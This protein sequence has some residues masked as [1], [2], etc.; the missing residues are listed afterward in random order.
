MPKIR[1]HGGLAGLLL[2]IAVPC[3]VARVDS[4]ASRHPLP[5]PDHPRYAI[6]HLGEGIGLATATVTSLVQDQKGF[7]WMGTQNGL[8]RFD[9]IK[10]VR[11]GPKSG[12]LN[13]RV[14][15]LA[16]SPEGKLW[17]VVGTSVYQFDGVGFSEVALPKGVEIRGYPQSVALPAG[18][19]AYLATESGLLLLH[20]AEHAGG[21]PSY[22]LWST[23]S[24]LPLVHVTA[25]SA[26]QDGTVWL[27]GDGKLGIIRP[28]SHQPEM[29]TVRG[30]PNERVF[31]ILTDGA[32][33]VWVRTHDHIGYLDPSLSSYV[34]ADAGIPGANDFGAPTL[35]RSGNLML[36]TVM[37]LFRRIDGEWIN[38]GEKQGL[39]TNAV[40]AALEDRE[41]AIW[42]GLGGAGVD[43]WAGSENWSGWGEAEGLPD[44]VVWQVVRDHEQRLWAG[45]NNGL[46]MWDAAAHRWRVWRRNDGIAGITVRSLTVAG[47]GTIWALS[48]P[49]GLTRIDPRTLAPA[50]VP[51]PGRND[52]APVTLTTS[53]DG[54]VWMGAR[55]A[56]YVVPAETGTAEPHAVPIPPEVRGKTQVVSFAPDGTMWTDG[57]AGLARFDGHQWAAFTRADGLVEDSL[58]L[59][60]AVDATT[61]WVCYSESKGISR[62]H[63]E[64]GKLTVATFT[65]DQGLT[66]D[67]VYMLGRDFQGRIW[68]GGDRG[69]SLLNE[70]GVM[71]HFD[72]ATGLLWDDVDEGYIWN[73][74]DGSVLIATSRGI[75]RYTP[76]GSLSSRTPPA[77][78]LTSAEIGGKQYLNQS[79]V[80][81]PHDT[82]TFVVS[83]AAMTFQNPESLRC[84]YRLRGL[85]TELQETSQR[86]VRY[87]ALPPGRYEFTVRCGSVITGW[88]AAP[89]A[90]AFTIQPPWWAS[91]WARIGAL[92]LLALAVRAVVIYR[93][94][95]LEGDRLMLE[96]AVAERS[97][98]LAR[99][100]AELQAMSLTDPLTKVRNRRFFRETI[101]ADA[102]QVVRAYRRAGPNA[103]PIEHGDLIYYFVD[104]DHF[105]R[106][107]DEY[108]HYAGDRVLMECS[109]RLTHIVRQSDLLIR[110]G[111]EEFLVVLRSGTR[112]DGDILA[113]RLLRLMGEE[114][115]DIGDGKMIPMTC[116]IGWAA[117]PWIPSQPDALS[118]DD[119]LVL[120]DRAMYAAKEAGRNYAVGIAPGAELLRETSVGAPPRVDL[121]VPESPLVRLTRSLG[122]WIQA[123]TA[124]SQDQ[125]GDRHT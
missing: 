9:G 57:Y 51:P 123:P 98:E 55:S 25:V 1:R 120:A 73:D 119:V 86:E 90:F 95:S 82:S 94:R 24:G 48:V 22:Q 34:P 105:K 19:D 85:E 47:N 32:G 56:L 65:T 109:R 104:L 21:P 41:R 35:D 43:R 74:P 69:I 125:E 49:G 37:G 89:A 121:L 118:V 67:S 122:S 36:P 53:P 13:D 84:Q 81:V 114:P 78:V 80:Q 92:L 63:L 59:V 3:L 76:A 16:E 7:L 101:E 68:A 23:E 75:S 116:S 99:A 115:F 113:R 111:G 4:P 64:D 107:N 87:P 10:A 27:G 108:G 5:L 40:Y 2:L 79:G 77:V 12:M 8:Y 91:W 29:V 83:F 39:A 28:G 66:S 42:M 110:W 96:Q 17:A 62:V 45:T 52:A 11:F 46:A 26:A 60:L 31:A 33:L 97:A 58:D 61:A 103:G 30:L 18:G 54:H 71:A 106:V 44:Y 112:A 50:I 6:Q 20:P 70:R 38:V 72:R 124:A 117:F 14:Q 100:N 15:Q 102:M 88:S 93:I